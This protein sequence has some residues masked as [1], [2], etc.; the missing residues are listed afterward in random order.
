M[1]ERLLVWWYG[2]GLRWTEWR[3]ARKGGD[4]YMHGKHRIVRLLGWF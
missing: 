3:C 2:F 4:H 1:S